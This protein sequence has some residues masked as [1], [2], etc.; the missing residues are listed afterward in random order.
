MKK[1]KL[2]TEFTGKV[3]NE[4]KIG[5]NDVAKVMDKALKKADVPL[6]YAQDY[7]ASL[8]RMAKRDSKQFFADYGDMTEEDFIEDVEYNMQNESVVAEMKNPRKVF[9]YSKLTFSQIE[10]LEDLYA[11]FTK[12]KKPEELKESVNEYGGA[13]WSKITAAKNFLYIDMGKFRDKLK[14]RKHLKAFDKAKKAFWEVVG[15]VAEE[16]HELYEDKQK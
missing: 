11:K 9:D 6:S 12:G 10:K 14:D 4:R 2:Y 7:A 8:E 13:E 16:H 3:L 15:P 5:W 1:V